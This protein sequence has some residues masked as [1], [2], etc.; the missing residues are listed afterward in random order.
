MSPIAT[1]V[2]TPVT[3]TPRQTSAMTLSGWSLI[4]PGTALLHATPTQLDH[5]GGGK[6][7]LA[8]CTKVYLGRFARGRCWWNQR[9]AAHDVTASGRRSS[10]PIIPGEC[11]AAGLRVVPRACDVELREP[12]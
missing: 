12:G 5:A 7:F 9:L 4:L 11:F 6:S 3:V 10:L 2:Y 8:V 1:R